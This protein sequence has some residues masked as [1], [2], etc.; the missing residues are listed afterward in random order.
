MKMEED[1]CLLPKNQI[2]P[3]TIE[4]EAP[5]PNRGLRLIAGVVLVCLLVVASWSPTSDITPILRLKNVDTTHV[6][7]ALEYSDTVVFVAPW[8]SDESGAGFAEDNP[9][10]T[11]Q[12]A[13]DVI[14]LHRA[15]SVTAM[16]IP[17]TVQLSSGVHHVTDALE[18]GVEDSYV[19]W[20]GQTMAEGESESA[21]VIA[22]SWHVPSSCWVPTGDQDTF[23]CAL[24]DTEL[25]DA[26]LAAIRVL[27]I[28][29]SNPSVK[30]AARYPRTMTAK[31]Y[32]TGFLF[33]IDYT[34][35]NGTFFVAVANEDV[36]VPGWMRTT[37]FKADVK[38]WPKES[39]NNIRA[40]IRATT[41]KERDDLSL[42]SNYTSWFAVSCPVT[43]DESCDGYDGRI[44]SGSR[45]YVM[46]DVNALE[47][48]DWV[49]TKETKELI[50]NASGL[51][52]K[53]RDEVFIPVSTLLVDIRGETTFDAADEYVRNVTLTG[54]HFMD[55]TY[56]SYGFQAGFNVVEEA[57]GIPTDAAVY[58]VAGAGISIDE[59]KFVNTGGGGVLITG[60]SENVN[61][62]NSH[63]VEM[64]QSGVMMTGN[65]TTQPSK[66]LVA[67]NSMLG[68]G[69]F[70]ASA[71]GIY[72]SSVSHSVFRHNHIEQ[73][74][75]WGIAIRSEE[76]ANATSVD[77][78]VEFNKLKT[79]G[80]STKDFGG[81]S[82]IGYFGV[83]D[84]DTTVRF[85]CV[86]E[87]IGV[88]SKISGGEPLM[89]SPYDSYGV[90]LD[91]EA[92]G[93]Y[94]TGN[95]IAKTVESGI[96]V[97]LGR[98]N[99]IDN[100]IFAFSSGYQIDAKGSSG[101]TVNNSFL[102]NIVIYRAS[103]DGQ[104]IYSSNFKKKYFSPVDWN[105]YYNLNST[106]EKSFLE[107][108]DL[109]PKGNWSTWRNDGFDAHSVV[110][111]PLFMDALRGDFR[112]RDNSP[113]FDLGFNALPDS[114]SI[115][116]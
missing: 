51:D 1:D 47:A 98:H 102:H 88:Y 38:Y 43:Y 25:T 68:I 75:R 105:T 111:D 44:E 17:M 106:F 37:D 40:S 113:A 3:V 108:G 62:V 112:L 14:R 11:L 80:Q 50:V 101:W 60:T 84:A 109:T 116:D 35:S 110:A 27:R 61:V 90:Y 89:E 69:R 36:E 18:L 97:H 22:G 91:N 103:S 99:R 21:T 114:V 64:G 115:C 94:V 26:Q 58:V 30:E 7:T 87:T 29:T 59:C 95:I 107:N 54:I 16:D 31:P 55:T 57:S 73:S 70:L 76:Q 67:H 42:T 72:G 9:L 65:K 19:T 104:L 5:A 100:N 20:Q 33:V 74:A 41:S 78:L 6:D 83:P 32:T 86:R 13:R 82:F 48:G 24:G 71:G 46:N 81:L 96:F 92:S 49:F 66:V 15:D 52:A 28:G 85:N 56:S 93:Y 10:R 34:Y 4:P 8:G 53:W 12:G 45:F 39:W 79:L 23:K 63:F 77:N 2:A